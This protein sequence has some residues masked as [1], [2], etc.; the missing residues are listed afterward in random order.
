MTH[1]QVIHQQF[2]LQAVP[3]SEARSMSDTDAIDLLIA[4]SC[5]KDSHHSLDVACGPGMVALAF[6]RV[7]KHAV[8]LD[9]TPAMVA[10]AKV[11]QQ[12]HSCSNVE[13]V[14]GDAANLPFPDRSFDVVT[15][16]FAFHHMLDA[17]VA[18]QEMIRVA[19]AG[20]MIVVCDG[21]ASSDPAKAEAFNAF[22]RMRD[23]STVRFRTAD[24]LRILFIEAGLKVA[25]EQ[26][27]RVPAELK[28]LLQTSFPK[29]EDVGTLRE[30]MIASAGDDALALGTRIDG[31]RIL[32]S[33]PA[34]ILAARREA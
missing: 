19:R 16:R 20:A 14:L 30:I 22:E 17:A 34:M 29:P 5:A 12:R 18:L 13:W 10:R 1:Q 3:F 21:V 26:S 6:A 7:V 31:D 11:L 27:Y 24:E 4:A 8:G 32:F 2:S 33:Y 9:T 25:S 23:P 15:C 28:G